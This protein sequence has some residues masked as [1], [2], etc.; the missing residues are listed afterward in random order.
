MK[1]AYGLMEETKKPTGQQLHSE[2]CWNTGNGDFTLAGGDPKGPPGR[3][4]GNHPG[5]DC[6]R[7]HGTASRVGDEKEA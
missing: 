5:M 3:E 7:V 2:Y 4:G 1:R 6:T